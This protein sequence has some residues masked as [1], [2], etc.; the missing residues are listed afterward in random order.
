VIETSDKLLNCEE[1]AAYLGLKPAAIRRL[2]YTRSLPCVRPTGR[3]AVRYRKSDLE[4]LL[5]M[6]SQPM[7]AEGRHRPGQCKGE[8]D[9]AHGEGLTARA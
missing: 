5:R 2:T 9:A 7:R 1:A 3:R 8:A 4:Q 6:R